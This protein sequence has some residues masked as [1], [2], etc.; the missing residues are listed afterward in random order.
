MDARDRKVIED[1]QDRLGNGR[2]PCEPEHFEG[3]VYQDEDDYYDRYE[4]GEATGDAGSERGASFTARDGDRAYVIT[5]KRDPDTEAGS[6]MDGD[7]EVTV[8]S[9]AAR[10][11]YCEFCHAADVELAAVLSADPDQEVCEACHA[12]PRVPTISHAVVSDDRPGVRG[13]PGRPGPHRGTGGQRQRGG[14]RSQDHRKQHR[15]RSHRRG[16]AAGV[17]LPAGT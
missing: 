2:P 10:R 1:I 14:P 12:N 3:T 15:H 4:I 16:R 13:E 9:P 7:T 6:P 11:G 5:V 17:R 8:E